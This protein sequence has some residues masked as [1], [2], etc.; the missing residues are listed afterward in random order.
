MRRLVP[1]L[2]RMLAGLWANGFTVVWRRV[3]SQWQSARAARGGF[4]GSR[5]VQIAFNVDILVAM[6]EALHLG[7]PQDVAPSVVPPR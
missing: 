3:S 2:A 7:L 5:L 6:D 1:S 4:Q